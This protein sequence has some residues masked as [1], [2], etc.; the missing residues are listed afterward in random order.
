MCVFEEITSVEDAGPKCAALDV[1]D[2]TMR[3]FVISQIL[4]LHLHNHQVNP[5][6]TRS[7][8][9]TQQAPIAS[10]WNT[11]TLCLSSQSP[12]LLQTAKVL[13]ADANSS[14]P[15]TTMEVRAVLDP[16]SQRSYVS[17]EVQSSLNLKKTR[18]DR[19]LGHKDLWE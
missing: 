17:T 3:A 9:N 12:V 14:N 1:E 2:A 15:A 13:V 16:G 11:S 19:V 6:Q 7:A 10:D 8:S 5:L 4:P 18:T